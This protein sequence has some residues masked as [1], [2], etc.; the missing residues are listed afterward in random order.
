[1]LKRTKSDRLEEV[2][3][4]CTVNHKGD[5]KHVNLFDFGEEKKLLLNQRKSHPTKCFTN[6]R[7]RRGIRH[8]SLSL[9]DYTKP[10]FN[11]HHIFK[12]LSQNLVK[13]SKHWV[14]IKVNNIRAH[15]K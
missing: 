11:P 15:Q 14:N 12:V 5:P 6:R 4:R 3:Q 10:K 9:L 7:N 1:M 8:K 13:Q 2:V